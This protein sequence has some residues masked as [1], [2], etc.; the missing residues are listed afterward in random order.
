MQASSGQGA[1]DGSYVKT[2]RIAAPVDT[3]FG[4]LSTLEGIRTWWDGQVEGSAAE[5][6]EL[7]FDIADSDDYSLMR[8]E[9]VVVP[10]DVVWSV[11]ED[12]GYSGE[13]S[14]TAI[15]FHLQDDVDGST[16]LA[17][18]HQGLTPAL[19]CYEDCSSGWDSYLSRMKQAAETSSL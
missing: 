10:T 5:E 2:A 19:D 13:W 16:T 14:N 7:R 6:G 15:R 17:L 9:S 12:S 1:D 11:I 8:V 3:V 4:L 18:H